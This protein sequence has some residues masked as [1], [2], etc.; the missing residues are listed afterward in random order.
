MNQEWSEQN[1]RMQSLLKKATFD[2][3][4]GELISLRDSLMKE[5]LSWRETL[6]EGDYSKIPFINADGYHS[7]TVAYSI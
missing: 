4:I 6:S 5:M 2:Q 7:K 1:K 3:G